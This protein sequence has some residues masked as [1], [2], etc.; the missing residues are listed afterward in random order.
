MTVFAVNESS[1]YPLVPNENSVQPMAH[2]IPLNRTVEILMSCEIELLKLL[3][4]RFN[5]RDMEN[6]LMAMDE[7]VIRANGMEGDHVRG[8]DSVR[9]HWTRQWAMID[10]HVEPVEFSIGSDGKIVD[11]VHQIVRDL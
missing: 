1:Q 2:V 6:V 4:D 8:R 7:D 3:Y 9:S 5:T 11:E 10:P